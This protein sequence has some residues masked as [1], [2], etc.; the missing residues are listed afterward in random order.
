MNLISYYFF[1]IL[2]Q[3]N[4]STNDLLTMIRLSFFIL[5]FILG[6]SSSRALDVSNN[7]VEETLQLLD[8]EISKRDIY[9]TKH[10]A[11]IDSLKNNLAHHK[12]DSLNIFM[13]IGD[14]YVA[15][16]ND[17]A[18]FYYDKGYNASLST[19][20]D[21]IA[22]IFRLKRDTFLPLAGLIDYAV[23]DFEKIDT[24]SISP[25]LLE[26]YYESGKQMFSYIASCYS[27]Y[28]T[29]Y[30]NW[31][32][33]SHQCQSH[34]LN[35]TD[36]STPKYNLNLGEFLLDTKEYAKAKAILEETLNNLDKNSNLYARA[37]HAL[38]T[39]A[40]IQNKENEY[41]SHLAQSTIADIKSATLEVVSMQELG[42]KLFEKGDIT[43]AHSY[44]SIALANAVKCKASM[45]MIH[46]SKAMPIIVQAHSAE[47]KD[48]QQLITYIIIGIIILLL[49]L[50]V[51]LIFL[52]IEAKR[53]GRVR[54]KLETANNVKE[55]Y[56]SQ[57]LNL[58][59][60]YM[61]KLT[62][63]S[64]TVNRKISAG[65]AEDLYKITKSGKFIEEQSREFYEVFDNAFLNIYPNF[66]ENINSLLQPE[67]QIELKD[68]EKLNTELR[69]LAFMKLG[70]EDSSKIAQMLNYSVNT[71]YAYRNKLKNKAL[72]RETFE[73]DVM[74]IKSI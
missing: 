21:S 25:N 51:I 4:N 13:N 52:R 60:I 26:L 65:K 72:N 67:K 59:S 39:I 32:N 40:L 2:R 44:S 29:I 55:I 68:D 24:S 18:I 46:S 53:L 1:V 5:C 38:A 50:V 73:D 23:T 12:N 42:E 54:R 66:I 48:W 28:P 56:I 14:K 41:I 31:K 34:L 20:N 7:K 63:F 64:D 27:N 16:D 10:Q 37:S 71:I 61:E 8:Q 45:R 62:Q 69:I 15:F 49:V 11:Q 3:N 30:N 43:R 9:I 17:S 6:V 36:K 33:K 70:I 58:C 22:T 47:I 74:K 35:L 19:K 57:F